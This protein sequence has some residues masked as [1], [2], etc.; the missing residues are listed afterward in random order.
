MMT[1]VR[2]KVLQWDLGRHFG[3]RK[4]VMVAKF[5]DSGVT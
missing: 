5:Q 1:M 3:M 4:W 2:E